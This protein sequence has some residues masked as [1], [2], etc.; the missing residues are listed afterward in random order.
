M[1]PSSQNPNAW[2]ALVK[3]EAQAWDLGTG[4]GK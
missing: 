2:A 1:A 3:L 4:M